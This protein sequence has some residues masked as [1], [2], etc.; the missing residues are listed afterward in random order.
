M[1]FIPAFLAELEHEAQNTRKLLALVPLDQADWAPHEKSMKLKRL[2]V[3]VADINAWARI[4]LKQDV[5]DFTTQ[6][7]PKPTIES[8]A[9]LLAFFEQ[10]LA[11]A[12][13]VLSEATEEQLN[14]MWTMRAGEQVYF[15]LPKGVVLR[16]FVF[17]HLVHHRAQLGVYLRLLNIP[18]PG[19][20]GPSADEMPGM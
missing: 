2:A 16:Q 7:F 20:Y 12:K 17:N 10:E 15:T 18:I 3:H 13:L 8:T 19:A 6:V 11:D 4:T 14:E 5:L 1:A 9:D